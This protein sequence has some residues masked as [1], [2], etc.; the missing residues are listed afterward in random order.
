MTT[1][2]RLGDA[3][4]QTTCLISALTQFVRQMYRILLASGLLIYQR[5]ATANSIV[6]HTIDTLICSL[7]NRILEQR[8]KIQTIARA[9]PL[10]F[11]KDT[12]LNNSTLMGRHSDEDE[13][14]V[15]EMMFARFGQP[16]DI[17]Q[18]ILFLA[19]PAS[20]WITGTVLDVNGGR[21]M[22]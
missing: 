11:A 4:T 7:A 18:A 10:Q 13:K 15:L 12:H 3:T 16:E 5:S 6:P 17:A 21:L 1:I 14:R 20:N 22:D 9:V 19:S 2:Q 8:T